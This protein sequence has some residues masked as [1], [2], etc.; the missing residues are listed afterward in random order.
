MQSHSCTN[1]VEVSEEMPQFKV[2]EKTS[3]FHLGSKQYY[4]GDVV[5]LP[6]NYAGYDFLTPVIAGEDRASTKSKPKGRGKA[7]AENEE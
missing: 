2:N 3:V 1:Y 7:E 6:E 5:E 4:P